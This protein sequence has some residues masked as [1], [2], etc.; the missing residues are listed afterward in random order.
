MRYT[1]LFVTALI[2][3]S[4]FIAYF[5]DLLGRRMGKKRLTLFNM[6]PRYTAIVITTITGMLI[7]AFALV[8]LVSVNSQFRK[9]LMR[10]EQ[11]LAQNNQLTRSNAKL[12]NVNKLLARRGDDLRKQVAQQQKEVIAAR[13]TADRAKANLAKATAAVS[14]LE[15]DIALR[16]K[17]LADLQHRT[18]AAE[19]ELRSREADLVRAKADLS[20]ASTRLAQAQTRLS[21]TQAKLKTKQAELDLALKTGQELQ[22][23]SAITRNRQF[24]YFQG[25]EIARGKINPGQTIF[26][27][28][29]DLY[30]LLEM[31]SD[32]AE[33]AGAKRG[34]NDRAVVVVFP[35]VNK[36]VAIL[37]DDEP[38]NVNRAIATISS[39]RVDVLVRVVCAVNTLP[40]EQVPVELRLYFND[41]VYKKGDRIASTQIDGKESEGY[42]L[43]ALNSFLQVDV[44]KA[45]MQAGVV[46]VATHDPRASLGSN[47]KEQADELLQTVSR[48]KAMDAKTNV[49]V[50]ATADIYAADSLNLNNIRFSTEK[51]E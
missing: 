31:A 22:V 2:C 33:K 35:V 50:F 1:I 15:K 6:R 43:L 19:S 37:V 24:I 46:P 17:Q 34:E 7:S 41:I 14:R 9:V 18:D 16:Q 23:E 47:R 21:D 49:S 8:T 48:I 36:K 42:I 10:G 3:V 29:G 45:A 20:K 28:K 11:I 44:A 27:L 13:A 25:D 38:D 51:A 40:D 30:S 12:G 4:G 26:G 39:S 5:G 32:K